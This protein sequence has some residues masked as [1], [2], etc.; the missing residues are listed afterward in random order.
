MLTSVARW[1]LVSSNGQRLNFYLWIL[2]SL[3]SKLN[4]NLN[5]NLFK[6]MLHGLEAV[7]STAKC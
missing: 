7:L 3:E 6:G 1:R 4:G 2:Y 5:F